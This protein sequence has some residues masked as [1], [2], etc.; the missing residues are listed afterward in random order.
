MGELLDDKTEVYSADLYNPKEKH[1][2]ICITLPKTKQF[3]PKKGKLPKENYRLSTIHFQVLLL[4]V[5]G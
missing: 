1:S 2:Q 4:L 5:S 3:A